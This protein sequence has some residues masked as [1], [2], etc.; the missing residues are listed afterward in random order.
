MKKV[1]FF[2]LENAH[3]STITRLKLKGFEGEKGRTFRGKNYTSRPFLAEKENDT[4]NLSKCAKNGDG[5]EI[6]RIAQAVVER[7]ANGRKFISIL[8]GGFLILSIGSTYVAVLEC[9]ASLS[10]FTL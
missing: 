8:Q 9:Y 2:T 4:E 3:I 1:N 7:H 5:G 6:A 10:Q